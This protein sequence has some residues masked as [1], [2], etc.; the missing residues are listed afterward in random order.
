MFWSIQSKSVESNVIWTPLAFIISIKIVK[1]F[2]K[3]SSF[4]I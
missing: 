1:T 4:V 3:I 2:Y